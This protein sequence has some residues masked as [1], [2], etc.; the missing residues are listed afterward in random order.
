MR[1][2]DFISQIKTD[3]QHIS[4]SKNEVADALSRIEEIKIHE[5]ID[6]T[7][8]ATE[9]EKDKEL[10]YLMDSDTIQYLDRTKSCFVTHLQASQDL[11]YQSLFIEEHLKLF[12]H[13]H[14]LVQMLLL[15]QLQ[16]NSYGL[17]SE[18]IARIGLKSILCQKSEVCRHTCA[19][20]GNYLP[21][22]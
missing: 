18:E 12:I 3:I 11:M 5:S 16:R 17:L 13:L 4:G 9:W 8:M 2:L 1:H 19:P 7:L 10:K 6:Y 14:T 20:L 15:K 21:V 22:T